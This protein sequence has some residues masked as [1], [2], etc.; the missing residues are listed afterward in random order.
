MTPCTSHIIWVL[1]IRIKLSYIKTAINAS[2]KLILFQH[3]FI[4]IFTQSDEAFR[5][6]DKQRNFNK[7][8]Q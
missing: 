4:V 5:V 2:P 6:N 1:P 7:P 8:M 3:G